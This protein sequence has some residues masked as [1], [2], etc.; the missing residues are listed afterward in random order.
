[1]SAVTQS[2]QALGYGLRLRRMI[3]YSPASLIQFVFCFLPWGSIISTPDFSSSSK[4]VAIRDALIFCVH[5]LT[6]C[7]SW[8]TIPE[9]KGVKPGLVNNCSIPLSP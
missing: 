1:M 7:V 8:I 5:V 6:K 9:H 4:G 2:F 3:E